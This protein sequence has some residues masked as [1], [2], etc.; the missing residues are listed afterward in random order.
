[1]IQSASY[2][3]LSCVSYLLSSLTDPEQCR[4]SMASMVLEGMG[5]SKFFRDGLNGYP[6]LLFCLHMY[7]RYMDCCSMEQWMLFMSCLSLFKNRLVREGLL[8]NYLYKFHR[9]S[10]L[11]IHTCIMMVFERCNGRLWGSCCMFIRVL[12]FSFACCVFM[13]FSVPFNSHIDICW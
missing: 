2:A 11:C 9:I 6:V 4:Q 5:L 1:M 13:I 10:V 7:I 3:C 8:I 12:V